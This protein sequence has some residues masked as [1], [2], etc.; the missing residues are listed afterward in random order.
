[1]AGWN[2]SDISSQS[3]RSAVITGTGGLGFQ[4][5]LAL[6]RAGAHVIIA[7]RKPS[8]GNH[9]V[10]Q[11]RQSVPDASVRFELLDLASL[12]SVAAF[13]ARLRAERDSIDLLINNA[14]VMTPP[15]RQVTSDGF[16][17]QLG[18]NYL[19]HFALTAHL[20]P[21]LRKGKNPRVVTVSSIAARNGAIN[22]EDL[23]AEHRYRALAVYSQSKLACLM[24]S[25]ELQR[26]SDAAAWGLASIGAHPGLSRTDL[27]ANGAGWFSAFG[28]IRLLFAKIL[29]QSASQGALPT[30]YA[31]TSP[32]VGPGTYHGPDTFNEMRGA[33][34]IAKP[35]L[36]ALDTN[37]AKRLWEVSGK[38]TGA[39]FE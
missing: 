1:M 39:R 8:K 36:Q 25:Y 37:V 7:G 13:G 3:G 15:K 27:V 23:Q 20:L 5:A 10:A 4:S 6:A 21:L 31:A 29:F 35:P 18:T 12:E 16:E 30:L 26:Q 34:T 24:F 22:F 11:I 33:P 32:N 2:T 9:A 17:L 28:V 14:A 19:G 38:L